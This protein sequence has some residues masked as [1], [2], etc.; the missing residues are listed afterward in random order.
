MVQLYPSSTSFTIG[1]IACSKSSFCLELGPKT[2]S[3][4]NTNPDE[5]TI[6]SAEFTKK[7]TE[8]RVI[9]CSYGHV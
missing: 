3:I 6:A 4:T 7:I 1:D 9:V 2:Y 5:C 8:K